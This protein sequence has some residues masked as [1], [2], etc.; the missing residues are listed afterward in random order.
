MIKYPSLFISLE[1]LLKNSDWFFICSIPSKLVIRLNFYCLEN[2]FLDF[3]YQ[4]QKNLFY[5]CEKTR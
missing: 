5:H 4:P 3:A 1:A 2:E